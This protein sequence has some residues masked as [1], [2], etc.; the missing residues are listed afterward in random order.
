MSG[1]GP[2]AYEAARVLLEAVKTAAADGK[3]TRK[4]VR[5]AVA[6]TK[7]QPSILGFPITF[8]PKGDLAGGATYVFQVKD[9]DFVLVDVAT[10]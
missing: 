6:A 7:D 5:D 3:I 2:A 1:F 10:K 9:G 4:E 8:D